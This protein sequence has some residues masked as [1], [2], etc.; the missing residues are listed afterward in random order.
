L[1]FFYEGKSKASQ[2]FGQVVKEFSKNAD[3]IFF[4]LK[5]A[6]KDLDKIEEYHAIQHANDHI[7]I[8]K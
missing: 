7:E 1:F 2:V 5:T 6:P 4:G 8:R 3:M